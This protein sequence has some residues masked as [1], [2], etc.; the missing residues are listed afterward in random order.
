MLFLES[1][2]SISS[3]VLQNCVLNKVCKKDLPTPDRRSGV[4]F[5]YKLK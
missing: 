4:I 5:E 1:I 3:T 2:L